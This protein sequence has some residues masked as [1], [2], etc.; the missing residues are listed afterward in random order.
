MKSAIVL[1][2][3]IAA[4]SLADAFIVN[5]KETLSRKRRRIL[6]LSIPNLIGVGVTLGKTTPR[7]TVVAPSSPVVGEAAPISQT[8]PTGQSEGASDVTLQREIEAPTPTPQQT[9]NE[10]NSGNT[11]RL[12]LGITAGVGSLLGIKAGIGINPNTNRPV[13]AIG[14][15]VG[16]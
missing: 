1:V 11:N 4:A 9:N 8:D 14:A 7:P 6:G 2:V 3:L 5:S 16:K 10:N 13:I 12:G 15:G